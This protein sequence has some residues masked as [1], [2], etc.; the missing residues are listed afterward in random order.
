MT[1]CT[2]ELARRIERAEATLIADAARSAAARLARAPLVRELCGGFAVC[3]EPGSPL[4][5]VAGL[6]FAGSPAEADWR[7]VEQGYNERDVDVVVE[8]SSLAEPPLV[9]E[10]AARGYE[11]VGCENVLGLEL[12]QARL[13]APPSPIEVATL[14]AGE[15]ELW[16]DVLLS[17]F[18]APDTAGVPSH[19]SFARDALEPVIRDMAGARGVQRQLA[20]C[21]GRPAG[22]AS[23]RVHDGI[24]QLCGAAT[25][26]A[27]RRRG[28]QS[29]LLSWRL[30]LARRT[31]CELAVVTTQPGSKSQQNVQR[32]GFALLYVR[33]VLVRRGEA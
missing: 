15:E 19:E 3:T 11:L 7:A 13:P 6:G 24:A 32:L 16:L 20:R 33:T 21:D 14:R 25:L 28:V 17:G 29:A 8:L 4:C 22:A 9:G 1:F 2:P 12:A 31:G 5:K 30:E 27:L 18:A 23:L 10:L 26:P